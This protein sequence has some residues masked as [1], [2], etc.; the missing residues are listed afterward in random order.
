MAG[1]FALEMFVHATETQPPNLPKHRIFAGKI[2][3]KGWLADFQ[4]L[5]DVFHPGV[6]VSAL[7]EQ[8]N[9]SIN[10]LLSQPRLFALT[11]TELLAGLRP[12]SLGRSCG[13][14]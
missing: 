4:K 13:E 9:R 6:F 5:H 7:A 3:E 10:D 2:A 12:P 8:S 11:E 14:A 1:E